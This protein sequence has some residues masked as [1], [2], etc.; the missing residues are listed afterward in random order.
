MGGVPWWRPTFR[1][2]ANLLRMC[3]SIS[4]FKKLTIPIPVLDSVMAVVPQLPQ[5]LLDLIIDAFH[6]S[7]GTAP[8][9]SLSLVSRAWRPRSQSNLFRKLILDCYLMKQIRS[10]TSEANDTQEITEA[11]SQ[12]LIPTVFSYVRKLHVIVLHVISPQDDGDYL[13]TLRLFN[14][15]T[16]LRILDWDFR[17][18]DTHHVSHFLG[19]F[20]STVRTLKLHEC[21]LDSEVLI[22]LTSMFPDLNDLEIDP[23]YP[24]NV[25]TYLIQNTDRPSKD[26]G[27]QGN[28][29]FRFLSAQHEGFISFVNEH[30]S[31]VRS[32]SAELC[33]NKGE[34]QRLF[35]CQGSKLT[36]VGIHSLWGQGQLLH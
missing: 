22:F 17:E 6:T 7:N 35:E 10:V 1:L 8:L 24:C 29:T 36:S 27:F 20:G 12:T 25:A 23:R 18:F 28:L 11:V 21:Q 2:P 15:V 14:N 4:L 5:E 13:E 31:D 16:S 32:I 19:H 30:S 34:M 26:V 9:K 33:V 3:P